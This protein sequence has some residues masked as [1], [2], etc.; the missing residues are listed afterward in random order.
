MGRV[1]FKSTQPC[2]TGGCHVELHSVVTQRDLTSQTS[3]ITNETHT[4]RL[5]QAHR[6]FVYT[7][8]FRLKILEKVQKHAVKLLELPFKG[9]HKKIKK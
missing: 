2:Y 1:Y 8:N 6:V 9:T 3:D 5:N 7:V 4:D